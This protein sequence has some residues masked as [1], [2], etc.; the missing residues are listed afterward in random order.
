M[1][2]PAGPDKPSLVG[3]RLSVR[4]KN[5]V[6]PIDVRGVLY[7]LSSIGYRVSSSPP[8]RPLLVLETLSGAGPVADRD[9]AVVDLNTERQ[10]L[11]LQDSSTESASKAFSQMLSVLEKSGAIAPQAEVWFYELHAR[12]RLGRS[13]DVIS[14]VNRFLGSGTALRSWNDALGFPLCISQIRLSTQGESSDSPTYFEFTI[15]PSLNRPDEPVD[16]IVVQ[17]MESSEKFHKAVLALPST[18]EKLTREI[19]ERKGTKRG[20]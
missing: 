4:F 2:P 10:F 8:P 16:I 15:T 17:R 5:V 18:V 9:G 19:G 11:G 13:G 1:Q 12:F 14:G 7:A 20:R 6:S 3:V